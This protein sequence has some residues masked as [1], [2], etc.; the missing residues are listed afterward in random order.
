[1][2]PEMLKFFI[3]F[4]ISI[5]LTVIITYFLIFNSLPESI[6]ELGYFHHLMRTPNIPFGMITGFMAASYFALV[7]F[8]F[9]IP[10]KLKEIKS[11]T[12][13]TNKPIKTTGHINNI[14]IGENEI[15]VDIHYNDT[16]KV[17]KINKKALQKELEVGDSIT[18]YYDPKKPSQAYLD[19]SHLPEDSQA[20]N[21]GKADTLFKLLNITPKF[22]IH[23]NAFELLG[24][25]YGE[26]FQ[27]KESSIILNLSREEL[28]HYTPGKLFPCLITGTK[29]DYSIQLMTS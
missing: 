14:D 25:I 6:R 15:G 23:K 3:S 5:T 27:G 29:N 19:L 1:M 10:V 9:L 20:S 8:I 26:D 17:F 13:L 24:E 18:V 21:I 4:I 28:T 11:T 12:T 7:P 16:R 2:R 22:N